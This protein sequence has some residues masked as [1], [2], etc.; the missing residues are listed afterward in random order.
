MAHHPFARISAVVLI[1]LIVVAFVFLRTGRELHIAARASAS[2]QSAADSSSTPVSFAYK[3]AWFAVKSNDSVV[4]AKALGLKGQRPV[5]WKT[6]IDTAYDDSQSSIFV[7]PPIHGWVLAVGRKFLFLPPNEGP[8]LFS[9]S[10]Q[11]TEAQ[12][13]AT[14]RISDAYMWER[15]QNGELACSFDYGDGEIHRHGNASA[16]EKEIGLRFFD[17]E[18]PDAKTPGYY[19]LKDL[20]FPDEEDVLK[21]AA[22]W[23]VD[24]SQ[25]DQEKDLASTGILGS[26]SN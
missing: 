7:T 17:S 25:L 8:M 18:S 6:G 1:L 23:S 15:A 19:D 20:N 21:V 5:S 2:P 16:V 12:F 14:M 13:F 22:L 3:T 26:L 4:V 11:F 24:P 10:R 9:L